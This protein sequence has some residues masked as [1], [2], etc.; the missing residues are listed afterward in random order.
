MPGGGRIHRLEDGWGQINLDYY[1]VVVERFPTSDG[2]RMTPEAFLARVRRNFN[3]FVDTDWGEFEP[4]ASGTDTGWDTENEARWLSADPL[5][6]VVHI[7]IGGPDNGSVIVSL[8]EPRRW[9]FSTLWTEVDAGHPVSGNREWGIRDNRNG[10]YTFYTRAADRLTTA[11]DWAAGVVGVPFCAAD[12]LWK[13]LQEGVRT[14]VND[15]GGRAMTGM[16]K[17]VRLDWDAVR[18]RFHRPSVEWR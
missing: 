1:P 15:N 5:G 10:T 14:Y 17:S 2:D 4:Y 3:D 8:A 16:S 18:N 9:R 12:Q 13:S 6:T 11:P 7:D